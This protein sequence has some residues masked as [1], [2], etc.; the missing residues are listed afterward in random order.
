MIFLKI[1]C[2]NFSILVWRRHTCLSSPCNFT[3]KSGKRPFCVFQYLWGGGGSRGNV[4]CS[5]WAHWKACN[6]LSISDNWTFS[7]VL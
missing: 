5:S 6:E 4:R 7:Y 2:P 1:N 3:R